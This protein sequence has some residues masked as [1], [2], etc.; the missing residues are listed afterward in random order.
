MEVWEVKA[1]EQ[2]T[3]EQQKILEQ[4]R[5]TKSVLADDNNAEKVF[6]SMMGH[7]FSNEDKVKK[8]D[9]E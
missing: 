2:L 5:K 8:E 7:D 9:T 1:S 4:K 3:H 6:T